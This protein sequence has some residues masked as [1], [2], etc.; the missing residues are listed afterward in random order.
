MADDNRIFQLVEEALCSDHAPEEVCADDP[1][2][3]PDVMAR[4][5][6]CRRIDLM[7]EGMFPSTPPERILSARSR[8]GAPLPEIPGY[9]VIAVLG[10][11]GY[12][13]VYRVKHL[14]LKRLAA[15]KMLLTGEY[16]SSSELARFMREAEAIA[17]LQHTNIVQIYEVGEVD[18]RP[19][20]TMEFVG[21]GTLA[22]KLG[23]VPQSAQ[24][25][26][27]V[28]ESL[29]RAIHTAHV[30]GIVHR[31]IKPSN[32]LLASDGTSKI[33][34]FGLARY[35]EG[36]ADVTLGP[37]KVGTPSYMA[38]EQ[39]VGNPG[40]VGPPA[41][42][43]GLGATLYEL[44]TGRPPFRGET[45]QETEKQLLSREA[46]PPSQLNAKVPRDLETVCL[47]CLRKEPARRYESALAL[48]D[49]LMRFQ[50]GRPIHARPVGRGE[51]AWCWCRRNPTIAVLLLMALALVG[52]VSGGGTWL[53][54]QR[55][56]HNKE[57][58]SETGTAVVEA[59]S[60]RD[61]YH[62]NEARALL[63]QARLRL[64][65]TGPEDLRRQVDQAR[66][67][68]EL[69]KKLDTA[70]LRTATPVDGKFKLS[71]AEPLYEEAFEKAGLGRPG[72]DGE[73]VAKRVRDS[74]VRAEIVAALDDWA[75]I[76][77]DQ[78]RQVWLLAVARIADPNSVRDRLRH[79]E[80]WRNGPA[81]TKLVRET[82]LVERVRGDDLSPQF[83][84]AVGRALRASGG[85][86]VPLLRAGQARFPQDFW[87][88]Q[89]LGQALKGEE[90]WDEAIVYLRLAAALRPDV[91]LVHMNLGVALFRKGQFDEAIDHFEEALRI[92]PQAAAGVHGNLGAAY[93]RLGQREKAMIHYK[94]A[95]R[96]DPNSALIHAQLGEALYNYG[97]VDDAIQ[98]FKESIRLDPAASGYAHYRL[99]VALQ[100]QGR[101]E[102]AIDHFRQAV[103]LDPKSAMGGSEL[104]NCLFAS[105]CA[106]VQASTG[107]DSGRLDEKERASLRQQA[108]ER[109][110]GAL[111]LRTK[112]L[113]ARN[114]MG[115]GFSIVPWQTD[116][117]LAGVRDREA[118]ET[119]SD[120]DRERWERFWKD[121]RELLPT[122]PRGQGAACAASGEWSK[123]VESYSRA[124]LVG[125]DDG[126]FWFEYSAV[127]LLSGD[128]LSYNR[129]CVHMVEAFGKPGGPRAYH[130]AR[131]CTLA[132]N[133]GA[134]PMLPAH[135]ARREL[136]A[137]AKQFWS[138]TEQGA[139]AFRA[140]QFNESV[141]LFEQSLAANTQPGAA[142]VNWL[143]LAL[144]NQRVGRTD[145]AHRW[146]EKA[147]TWLDQFHD[148]L[149][150]RAEQDLGLHLH[151]WLEANVLR[152]EAEALLSSK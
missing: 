18:G 21:G 91:G 6:E 115:F 10:R 131:A 69:A 52:M 106:A 118:L 32:I 112:L 123:A 120:V 62:Y 25:A 4:L 98:N 27:S 130:I 50:D 12:G 135:L 65:S 151:N 144:A 104:F 84:N 14:K 20:F 15:L 88:N 95:L 86:A 9:E 70:R 76:T 113:K 79:A 75:C 134:D 55:S 94:E 57:L 61:G 31:D 137:N 85:D 26:V 145:E 72:D 71:G 63:E 110:K 146:L 13:I 87:L 11:G 108:L 1:E 89:Q 73:V 34:D 64:R 149:P 83:V 121:V 81:L 138:L 7:V 96:F 141:P 105:A 139:L 125:T 42:I 148:G 56:Q 107:K 29:A 124:L 90:K 38:P 109:L 49:D 126:E 129:A 43:Y 100:D 58:R 16:A 111:E 80:L 97:Q 140:G 66:A 33:S 101:L 3:L 39:I 82:R 41:D 142:V 128:Q 45:A 59:A 143:W 2:L 46:V 103:R 147:Q 5:E 28:T 54:Q 53:L 78:G 17:A 93:R 24:Y 74:A 40:T 127:L 60:F 119:L 19:F 36:Q 132:P 116:P 23:G 30:A 51:R 122:D 133:A 136:Q 77:P 8:P 37:A 47:K 152:R 35:L 99:G 114:E 44:L 22:Q 150:P 67:D 48:A 102:D 117:A 92:D 68:L